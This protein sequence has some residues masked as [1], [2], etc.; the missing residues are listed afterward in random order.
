MVEAAFAGALAAKTLAEL[1]LEALNRRHLR[2][3]RGRP[4]AL[5]GV[6]D[7]A[8]YAKARDYAQAKSRLGCWELVYDAGVLAAVVLSGA[9]P[10][11][12][13]A[14]RGWLGEGS[15]ASALF[16]VAALGALSLPGLPFAYWRQFRLEERF[17]F[18]RSS[19]WLWALDSLKG[20]GLGLAIGFP[21]IWLLT[22]LVDWLGPDWWLIGF[23]VFFGFQLAM[24]S[25]YPT[26]IM[27][28]FNKFYPLEDKELERRLMAL[29]ERTGFRARSILAMDGSKRSAHSNAFFAGFGRFRRIVLFDTLIEQLG[30]E[31][32][33]AVLAHEIGHYKLGHIPKTLALMAG[34]TL[35]A[36]WAIDW[37]AFSPWFY[38]GFGF[39]E[40]NLAVAL[41]LF[42]LV[43]GLF[44]FWLTPL[45]NLLSRKN[46]YEADAFAREAAGN[47]RP[48]S[49]A[50][51][52]LTEK[53]LSN[54]APHPL[55]S[56]FHYSHPTL[57]ERERALR[58]G[59]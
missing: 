25:L 51:R 47:W 38:E 8:T 33:E 35:A 44:F 50:L 30:P 39:A 9:L 56:G 45:F 31:E 4:E 5:E 20:A 54:P 32:L 13:E 48:L 19:R 24:A 52:R 55:Y 46:E 21:L 49:E 1:L 10:A 18:N 53:N 43:G 40:P 28:L 57:P 23:A 34:L 6:M 27:P 29:A 3:Q 11:A 15:A 37:L 14:W 42:S 17:G 16:V 2:R 22:S 58:G 26:L 59:A 41:L 36:F 7:E 12:F